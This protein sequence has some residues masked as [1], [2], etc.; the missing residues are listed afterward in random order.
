MLGGRICRRWN[1]HELDRLHAESGVDVRTGPPVGGAPVG[2]TR[3][4]GGATISPLPAIENHR[5]VGLG[6]ESLS[7]VLVEPEMMTGNDE[8]V[9]Q[10]RPPSNDYGTR[11]MSPGRRYRF[12]S[13]AEPEVT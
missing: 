11:T 3:R 2:R 12:S 5:H 4:A 9:P 8:Q 1:R 7:D 10:W 6:G 13:A